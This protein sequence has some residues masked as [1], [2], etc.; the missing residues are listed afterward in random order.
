MALQ[1]PQ[2]INRMDEIF[3]GG[4][5]GILLQRRQ[6][7]NH[8]VI[9]TRTFSVIF[10]ALS[11]FNKTSS[12]YDQI[13]FSVLWLNNPPFFYI[14]ISIQETSLCNLHMLLSSTEDGTE[15]IRY[16]SSVCDAEST[17][18]SWLW[19]WRR[20]KK[21]KV[22]AVYFPVNAN[23]KMLNGRHMLHS[24]ELPAKAL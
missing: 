15:I 23:E 22:A 8:S 5:G 13:F 16:K 9:I 1:W 6:Q 4:G 3:G 12:W 10:R 14:Y 20:R 21:K 19:I 17:L 2:L 18:L 11:Q 24:N 7:R